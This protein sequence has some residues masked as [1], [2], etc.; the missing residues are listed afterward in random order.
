[1]RGK[2]GAANELPPGGGPRLIS[3]MDIFYAIVFLCLIWDLIN[4]KPVE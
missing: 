3:P 4:S 1:M 2:P